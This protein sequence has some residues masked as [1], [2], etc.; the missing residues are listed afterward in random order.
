MDANIVNAFLESCIST[1]KMA[2]D[3]DLQIG[4][5]YV[6]TL[7]FEQDKILVLV[8]VTGQMAGSCILA[9]PEHQATKI[10]ADIMN[11]MGMGVTVNNLDDIAVSALSEMSN[12]IM[13]TASTN[14]AAKEILVDITPPIVQKGMNHLGRV[15]PENICVPFS[16]NG[17]LVVEINI[18]V[19]RK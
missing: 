1:F 9:I 17:E 2:A 7:N 18:A 15:V 12:M 14:L 11:K 16:N 5:P 4:K 19:E 3:I 10:A 6:R 13:G 8:G